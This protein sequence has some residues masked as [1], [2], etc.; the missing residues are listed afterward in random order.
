MRCRSIATVTVTANAT[1]T[2]ISTI[3]PR[4]WTTPISSAMGKSTAG[5]TTSAYRARSGPLARRRRTTTA[6]DPT[7]TPSTQ[8]G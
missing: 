1:A 8:A 2:T 7:A 6:A 3:P 4:G 5:P